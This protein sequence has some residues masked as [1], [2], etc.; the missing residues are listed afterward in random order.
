M[1]IQRDIYPLRGGESQSKPQFAL[2]V[3]NQIAS[4]LT[5][6][7][8]NA[9]TDFTIPAGASTTVL[10]IKLPYAPIANA[11]GRTARFGDSAVTLGGAMATTFTTEV[12]FKETVGSDVGDTSALSNGQYMIDYETGNLYGKKADAGTTGT[13][14]Y[15]YWL[16]GSVAGS[17]ASANQVQ[18]TAASGSTAVGNPVQTGG[19]YNSTPPTLTNGQVS[20]TQLNSEGDTKVAE[21]FAAVA[22]DNTNG[23]LATQVKPLATSAYSYSTVQNLSFTTLNAKATPGNVFSL[24]VINTT[25]SVRYL[26]LFNTAT[27]PGGGATPFD[28]F[29]IPASGSITIPNTYFGPGGMQF[30][31]G[32]AYGN[33]STAGTYTA[34][35]AGDLLLRLNYK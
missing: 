6:T 30:S 4:K 22:E 3:I 26:Q 11:S 10:N 23:V 24:N 14:A 8:F 20:A 21:Q 2:P 12:A 27:V 1:D 25:A 18:G 17:G 32:I 31:T 35:S 19:V 7:T 28:T 13:A 29:L 9:G 5:T 15:T 34:G 16:G 33:S